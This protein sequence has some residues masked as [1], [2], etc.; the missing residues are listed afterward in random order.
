MRRRAPAA[1]AKRL[2]RNVLRKAG[3]D[4]SRAHGAVGTEAALAWLLDELEVTVVLD[5]GA[6][7]GEF[8]ETLRRHGYAGRIVSFEPRREAF[9]QLDERAAR[10]PRWMAR[11]VALGA[12]ATEVTVNVASNRVSSS[13][14]EME[15]AHIDAAPNAKYVSTERVAQE[16]L[17]DAVAELIDESDVIAVKLDVQGYEGVVLEGAVNLLKRAAVLHLEL[18]LE[19]VY[20]GQPDWRMMIDDLV[21]QGFM[22][23]AL[24]PVFCNPVTGQTLQID[25]V[26]RRGQDD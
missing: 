21:E 11:R 20:K 2:V 17:D 6:N 23:Y 1:A 4:I 12:T 25:A 7:A 24:E 16:R 13:I 8:V 3:L 5:V 14:L 9:I 26:F 18:S 10:D 15:R 22:L 19:A